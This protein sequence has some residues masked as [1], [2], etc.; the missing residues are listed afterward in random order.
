MLSLFDIPLTWL[1]FCLFV[2]LFYLHDMIVFSSPGDFFFLQ[3]INQ[4]FHFCR[5]KS[6]THRCVGGKGD[7]ISGLFIKTDID[8]KILLAHLLS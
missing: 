5:M 6:Q 8:P 7:H 2:C 3:I 1:V 4:V